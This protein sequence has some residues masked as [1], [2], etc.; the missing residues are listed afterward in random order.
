M[1]IVAMLVDLCP[2]LVVISDADKRTVAR[3]RS[4]F[5]VCRRKYP[6]KRSADYLG[7]TNTWTISQLNRFSPHRATPQMSRE[8]LLSAGSDIISIVNYNHNRSDC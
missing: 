1:Q 6:N 8:V 2:N 4:E 3:A 7:I 5:K